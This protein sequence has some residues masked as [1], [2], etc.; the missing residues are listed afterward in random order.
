VTSTTPV[1]WRPDPDRVERANVTRL[2]R[3][4]GAHDHAA[5]LERSRAEPE[6]FWAAVVEDLGIEFARS[7]A[8]VL[9]AG[10]GPQWARWFEGGTINLGANCVARHARARPD[11]LAV[12]SEAEDG[13]QQRLTYAE[14]HERV[15]RAAAGLAALGIDV[16][17]RVGLFL[18]LDVDAVV[19]LYAC[20]YLG[21]IAV[22]MFSGF[23]AEAIAERLRGA[24]CRVLLTAGRGRRRGL[25]VAMLDTAVEAAGSSGVAVVARGAADAPVPQGVHRWDA[26]LEAGTE[27]LQPRELPSETPVL[28][29]YTSGTTGRP[30]AV[31]H[32]HGGFLVKA[33]SEVAYHLDVR[34]DDA[35]QWITDLGWILG[36]WHLVGTHLAGATA[37][38]Y[39]GAP[40]HPDVDRLWRLYEDHRVTVAGMSPTL[41]RALAAAGAD[42]GAHDLSA[43]R[44]LG[45]TGEPWD[46]ASYV[47]VFER[48]GGGRC[49]IINLS[50]GTEVGACFLGQYPVAPAKACS[51]G[52]PSL[53]M[54]V[55]VFDAAGRPVRGQLGELVCLA[56][57]PGQTRGF[58]EDPE[59]YLE[60]YWSRWPGVWA[61][62]DWASVDA[63]GYWFLHGRSDDTLKVAGKRLG[64]A[65]VEAAALAVDGVV[66]CVAVG[67]PDDVKGEAIWCACVAREGA[68]EDGLEARVRTAVA[69]ELG[70]AFA[71]SRV[72]LVDDLPRT[73]SGKLVRRAV[74]DALV[75]RPAVHVSSL[76]NPQSL[77]GLQAVPAPRAAVAP[78]T[79][80]PGGWDAWA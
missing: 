37:V 70:K 69:A 40:D 55:D 43:L 48:V 36:P 56:P 73:R 35:V 67:M 51:L 78:D 53:G 24:R 61:H 66:Q 20:A 64:P 75:G 62:G 71:P 6:A 18:P 52:G 65:E 42:P 54:A 72:L 39:P 27:S 80:P 63:D 2:A 46:P 30:K 28:V 57:W 60:T 25:P 29:L 41:A 14:L 45:S 49:P 19:A 17:D 50:G 33:G 68:D 38:L 44:I 4:L 13:S 31:V 9:D 59:R 23:A 21:A 79:R 3:R 5:L 77:A 8:T 47:W 22:P 34:A 32:V 7:Y 16:G 26:V 58:L 76:A 12:V 1:I 11:A 15:A 10:D 74:R